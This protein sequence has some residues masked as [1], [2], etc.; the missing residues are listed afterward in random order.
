[1]TLKEA[2]LVRQC[3]TKSSQSRGWNANKSGTASSTKFSY[4]H[5]SVVATVAKSGLKAQRDQPV[6]NQSRTATLQR[7]VCW[8]NFLMK[9]R[10]ALFAGVPVCFDLIFPQQLLQ[11]KLSPP[12][13][14]AVSSRQTACKR[15]QIWCFPIG[16]VTSLTR[17]QCHPRTKISIGCK[18]AV[19][20][21]T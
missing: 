20:I 7:F 15:R 9:Q 3:R 17:H 11:R 4:T 18:S 2:T 16:C 1:M 5:T 8:R 10:H 6:E 19:A 13:F 14:I 12:D 21:V